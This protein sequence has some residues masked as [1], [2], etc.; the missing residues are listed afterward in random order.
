MKKQIAVV[1]PCYNEASTIE[2]VIKG[3]SE[4]IDSIYDFDIYVYDNNSKDETSDLSRKAGA[5]IRS[6]SLQ[7]KG[8][9]VR[10]IFADVDADIYVMVDGDDTYDPSSVNEMICL[11]LDKKLDM[12][13]GVRITEEENAYRFGHKFGN[14]MLTSIVKLMFGS[15]IS[16]MLS[17]KFKSMSNFTLL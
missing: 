1:I 16:D 8:N 12:V 2:S 7:G 10:R 17:G 6:E 9:V 11:L 4:S 3:F 13:T 14:W 5:N 15:E